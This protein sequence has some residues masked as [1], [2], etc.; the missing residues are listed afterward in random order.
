MKLNISSSKQAGSPMRDITNA[1]NVKPDISSE[2]RRKHMPPS[3]SG[4]IGLHE[5]SPIVKQ[6]NLPSKQV[7]NTPERNQFSSGDSASC[8][9][10]L[11]E[12]GVT[13]IIHIVTSTIHTDQYFKR[14]RTNPEDSCGSKVLMI[15]RFILFHTCMFNFVNDMM[16]HITREK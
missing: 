3:D 4:S 10:S 12:P 6:Q 7:E 15:Q 11:V 1:N 13:S 16:K 9:D 14:P 2:K 8:K 5:S